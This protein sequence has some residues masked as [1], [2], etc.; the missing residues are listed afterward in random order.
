MCYSCRISNTQIQEREKKKLKKTNKRLCARR[1][2]ECTINTNDINIKTKE[3][4]SN[5]E[6]F[7]GETIKGRSK[8]T[9][10]SN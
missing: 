7:R 8:I 5:K 2:R 9:N 4:N 6:L 3:N 1:L 10:I